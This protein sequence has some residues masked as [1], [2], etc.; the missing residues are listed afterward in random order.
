MDR[1]PT[2]KLVVSVDILNATQRLES[3][4]ELQKCHGIRATWSLAEPA[5]CSRLKDLAA[6]RHEI[7]LL[8]DASWIGPQISRR[9]FAQNLVSRLEA[10]RAHGVR[11]ETLALHQTQLEQHSDLLVKANIRAIRPDV[12]AGKH[13]KS[14]RPQS[15][16]YG[17]WQAPASHQIEAQLPSWQAA[18][19]AWSIRRAIRKA[20][21]TSGVVHLRVRLT[22]QGL[23]RHSWNALDRVFAYASQEAEANRLQV[24]TIAQLVHQATSRRLPARRAKSI[25]RAA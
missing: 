13:S 18:Q 11:L 15:I 4:H 12:A 22:P 14:L 19:Q 2:G 8:G 23:N 5:Q 9:H 1:I 16:R 3:L 21:Q 7:G 10:V 25:L 6:D 17:V 20:T 24:L